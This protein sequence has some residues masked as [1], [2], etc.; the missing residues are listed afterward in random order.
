MHLCESKNMNIVPSGR[1]VVWTSIVQSFRSVPDLS[2]PEFLQDKYCSV[3]QIR[4]LMARIFTGQVLLNLLDPFQISQSFFQIC[5]RSLIILNSVHLHW[6][7]DF[8]IAW[9]APS[10][11]SSPIRLKQVFGIFW[12]PTKL[13]LPISWSSNWWHLGYC[14]RPIVVRKGFLNL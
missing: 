6:E 1:H 5:S 13:I 7:C 10:T 4:S 14:H 9:W 3:F 2:W 12:V 8:F 11:S